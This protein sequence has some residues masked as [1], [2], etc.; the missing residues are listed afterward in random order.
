VWNFL[1]NDLSY[2]DLSNVNLS[3]SRL[4]FSNLSYT[5]LS[6]TNLENTY[7]PSVIGPLNSKSN[8]PKNY[9]KTMTL[10]NFDNTQ[11]LICRWDNY[12]WDK[13]LSQL[14]HVISKK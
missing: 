3:G 2:F 9:E 14:H 8:K 4:F 13:Y 5:N 11:W 1:N 6:N 7:L 10:E 12:N